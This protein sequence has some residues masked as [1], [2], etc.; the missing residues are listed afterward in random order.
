M[1]VRVGVLGQLERD[2]GEDCGGEDWGRASG[3][4]GEGP[5]S[6]QGL[7]TGSAWSAW[8]ACGSGPKSDG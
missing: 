4:T 6:M 2:C 1:G 3:G 8:S 7:S 5:I